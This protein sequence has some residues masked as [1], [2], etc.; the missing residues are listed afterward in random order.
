MAD[1]SKD[2]AGMSDDAFMNEVE[3]DNDFVGETTSEEMEQAETETGEVEPGSDTDAEG[4][5]GDG[6]EHVESDEDDDTGSE[7]GSDED[8]QDDS[9]ADLDEDDAEGSGDEGDELEGDVETDTSNQDAD[10][11]TDDTDDNGDFDFKAGYEK[12]KGI[13]EPFKANGREMKVDNVEDAR[14]LMQMGA[15]AVKQ[16]TALKPQLKIIKSLQDNGLLDQDKVNLMIDLAKKNPEAIARLVK[17]SGIN[18]LDIDTDKAEGYKPT[19]YGTSD[20]QFELDQAIDNIK[21]NDSYDKSISVMGEQWDQKSRGIIA[22]HPEI[23]GVIDG[24][25]QS[26]VFDIV[27]GHVDTER[28]LG[29]LTGMSDVEAYRVAAQQLQQSGELEGGEPKKAEQAADKGNPLEKA[30]KKKREAKRK[31]RRKAAAPSKGKSSSKQGEEDFSHLSDEE[32]E[33]KYG[34]VSQVV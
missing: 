17:E 14:R 27:Q 8:T 32:F 9:D 12:V 26:G 34:A 23:V 10:S 6:E 3:G 21:G 5:A 22:E 1:E 11:D 29:R 31:K 24:H 20:S 16:A 2:Y 13:F 33:K 18:P 15:G 28:A 7:E 25:I 30:V 4:T 19:E